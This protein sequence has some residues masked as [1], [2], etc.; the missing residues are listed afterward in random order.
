MAA[1]K[2]YYNIFLLV[3]FGLFLNYSSFATHLK[4]GEITVKRVSDKT[5]TFEF[6]LTTYTEDN[7]ANRDQTDVSFCFGDGSS[8]VKVPRCCGT[9]M[10]IG[11]GTLKNI[12]KYTY[13]YPAAA[14]SYKV[15]VA[16][17]NRNE[18]VLN[19]TRSVEVPF[20]V[21]TIFSIN[22]GLGQNSTPLLLNPAVDLTAVVGQPFIHNPNAVDAEGDSLAYRLSVSKTGDENMCGGSGRGVM[23]PG[24]RQPNDSLSTFT[25]NSRTGDLIWDAP[26]LV[27]KYNCA[28]I[29]EEWRNG[30]KISETVRDMQIEVKDLDNKGPKIVVPPGVCVTAGQKVTGSITATDTP[31]KTGRLDPLTI[32]SLG[33]VYAID[34]TYAVKPP[35]A[36]F[37]SAANQLGTAT[38]SFS[39]QTNCIHVNKQT[40]DVFF[41]VSDNPPVVNGISE[42]LIDSKIWKIKVLA[43]PVSNLLA[44]IKQGANSILVSWT[45][46]TC[47]LRN[48]KIVL[49]K[50]QGNCVEAVNASCGTG[51]TLSG[52]T[53]IARLSPSVSQFEDTNISRNKNYVYVAVV[54]FSDENGVDDVSPM[55]N[56]TCIYIPTALPLITNVSVVKTDAVLGEINVKWS[57]P[58]KLDTLIYKGPYFYQVT[59]AEGSTST[60]YKNVSAFLPAQLSPAKSDT[61][62]TD[63]G[64]NTTNKIYAY[65]VKFY[66][67]ENG[68]KVLMD[69]TNQAGNVYL[70]GQSTTTTKID[71]AWV[72]DVPWSNDYQIHRLYRETPTKS[73]KWNQIADISVAG[74][75]TFVYS[76]L[77]KDQI[78]QDGKV[79]VVFQ[80]D[81]TYCYIVETVGEYKQGL[82][83]VKLVNA[84]QKVCF[85]AG[86]TNNTNGNGSGGSGSTDPSGNNLKPCA[87]V[88]KVENLDCAIMNNS[89]SCNFDFYSNALTWTPTT[90]TT[91][92]PNI[93][94]YNIYYANTAS[95][96]FKNILS[97]DLTSKI[98]LKTDGIRGCYYVTAVNSQGVESAKSNVVCVDN[99]ANFELP[100]LFTP[101]GDLKNDVWLPMRCPRFVNQIT[102]KIVDRYG[103]VVYDYD[104]PLSG[105]GWDGKNKAGKFAASSTYF[106]ECSVTFDVLDESNKVKY[107]K[108]W[109]ELVK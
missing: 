98:H 39:W 8:I 11:N 27:G 34:T 42:K 48:P 15:S 28:F 68:Q 58:I 108:G 69:A 55:S 105:F 2:N 24:F 47:G 83:N 66:Y 30:V 53:Q 71:L 10:S 99:C 40:Y 31:S 80:K 32:I 70:Y 96:T 92:D 89:T 29:I 95:D 109:V 44:T 45:P 62:F 20:Y 54:E 16:I 63:I 77:G 101:N 43:P 7:A 59:R 26:H 57:R 82:P 67:S 85:V 41:K 23:A 78:D 100:N 12:Y 65:K 22:A 38:G 6:T 60:D 4:G 72:A 46:Y 21:E 97:T 36:V 73:G 75:S 3:L 37:T 13:T 86:T 90:G 5:L 35:Y 33:N 87:P 50:K 102:C 19:I 93:L 84:S 107:L 52:F 17:P 25:I 61:S 91:C 76:D 18:G 9:P 56:A 64:L 94:K 49:Y 103:Q 88:L 79:D 51:M 14:L 106:Y 81:S 74:Q 104:G 1:S